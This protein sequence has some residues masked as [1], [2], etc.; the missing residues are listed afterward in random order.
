M[1]INETGKI[2]YWPQEI[3]YIFDEYSPEYVVELYKTQEQVTYIVD[4]TKKLVRWKNGGNRAQ[5]EGVEM[6]SIH[7]IREIKVRESNPSIFPKYISTK[8]SEVDVNED[9]KEKND[10]MNKNKIWCSARLKINLN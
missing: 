6:E 10:S 4:M 9:Y 5:K 2:K 7:E 8:E 1:K 3:I